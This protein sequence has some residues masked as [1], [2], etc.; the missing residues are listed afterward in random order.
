MGHW[1]G[2]VKGKESNKCIFRRIMRQK[3]GT[4]IY[5]FKCFFK[6]EIQALTHI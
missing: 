2:K 3:L 4:G 5:V 6:S 1:K